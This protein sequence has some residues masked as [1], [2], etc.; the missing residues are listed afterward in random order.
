M[1]SNTRRCRITR[2]I[3]GQTA[4]SSDGLGTAGEPGDFRAAD[5][6]QSRVQRPFEVSLFAAIAL[7]R[8]A[9]SRGL[10]P[11]VFFLSSKVEPSK[12]HMSDMKQNHRNG[13]RAE[14]ASLFGPCT[15]CATLI[16]TT[17]QEQRGM[18]NG[19]SGI[20]GVEGHDILSLKHLGPDAFHCNGAQ[21]T[22]TTR[23]RRE[24]LQT[25]GKRD[26]RYMKWR[27]MK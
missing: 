27:G 10:N 4:T 15:C 16:R 19:T 7:D 12:A 18:R 11:G 3:R 5:L 9:K 26:R 22:N 20:G 1:C 13:L 2:E 8:A 24:P 23:H 21:L 6:A 17:S 14:S 25:A